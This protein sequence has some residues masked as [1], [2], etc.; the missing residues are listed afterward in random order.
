VGFPPHDGIEEI[1]AVGSLGG[2]GDDA[3]NEEGVKVISCWNVV[4]MKHHMD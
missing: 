4:T 3:L 2:C 1:V